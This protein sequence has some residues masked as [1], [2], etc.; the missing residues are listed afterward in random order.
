MI[1]VHISFIEGNKVSTDVIELVQRAYLKTYETS[2]GVAKTYVVALRHGKVIGCLGMEGVDQSG[3]FPIEF[4]YGIDRSRLSVPFDQS[5][6]MQ[7]GRLVVKERELTPVIL[8]AGSW[9]GVRSGKTYG[10]IEHNRAVHRV[11]TRF[12]IHFEEIVCGEANLELVAEDDRRYY[13]KQEMRPYI[14]ELRDAM[15]ALASY[16]PADVIRLLSTS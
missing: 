1:D 12:G 8:Y 11:V 7:F 4:I 5:N 10:L 16:V 15:K 14:A 6:T 13:A 3:R 9:Y 2:P